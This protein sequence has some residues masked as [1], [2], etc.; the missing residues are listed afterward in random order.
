GGVGGV[1]GAGG[2]GGVGGAGG[3]GGV[4]G[5]G[6]SGGTPCQNPTDCPANTACREWDCVQ[7]KCEATDA[8][9]GMGLPD[10]TDGDCKD[11]VCDGM[12]G[13]REI[14]DEQDTPSGDG[15]PCT[16]SACVNGMPM[17]VPT[18]GDPCQGG[19][20][21]EAGMCVD[22][23]DDGDCNDP[24]PKCHEYTCVA[25]VADADCTGANATCLPDH[26]CVACDDGV[27]NGD[28]TGVD[29]GGTCPKKCIAAACANN[30][31][32]GSGFCA[33]G[34]CCDT[35]CTGTCKACN[36]MGQEGTCS[37]VPVNQDDTN[38]MTTCMGNKAC[39]GAGVCKGEVGAPCNANADCLTNK[40]MGAG[41]NKTCQP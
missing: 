33:D 16:D 17:H 38:A 1:G 11:L 30:D 23:L 25:C 5:A 26:T 22:C 2:V 34:V 31:E 9:D 4:G 40:C 27:M 24:T 39:D 10:P 13:E 29:C 15:N 7:G 28:E 37:N 14:D 19:V 8:P 41:A 21:N 36:V 35:D 12:G 20:C 6:G 32:C 18:P 3:V